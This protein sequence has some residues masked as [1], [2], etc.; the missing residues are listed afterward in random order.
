MR[1]GSSNESARDRLTKSSRLVDFCT[2][3]D[4]F[5]G[6]N[7][8]TGLSSPCT[9]R[10]V[11]HPT[12]LW[13]NRS[14]TCSF[15]PLLPS[16]FTLSPFYSPLF[17][18]SALSQW[19]TVCCG[20]KTAPDWKCL[21]P[22]GGPGPTSGRGNGPQCGAAPAL[23]HTTCMSSSR[24]KKEYHQV[25]SV[26]CIPLWLAVKLPLKCTN[27]FTEGDLLTIWV[28]LPPY[29]GLSKGFSFLI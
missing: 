21:S 16:R 20:T 15:G 13:L 19:L 29:L 24:Q 17:I 4:S 25:C 2:S 11:G 6:L 18:C 9:H 8:S 1:A 7:S 27:H 28:A 23:P 10:C 22:Q 5:Y 14:P 26:L 3:S 12:D